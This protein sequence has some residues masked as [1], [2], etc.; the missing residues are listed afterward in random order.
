MIIRPD[1]WK[2]ELKVELNTFL[3]FLKIEGVN[4]EDFDYYLERF[5]FISAFIIRKLS[6]SNK[7]TDG[8]INGKYKVS[9]F[10]MNDN[11]SNADANCLY[12]ETKYDVGVI[13]PYCIFEDDFSDHHY[14]ELTLKDILNIIIHSSVLNVFSAA[15]DIN[16]ILITTEQRKGKLFYIKFGQMISI[17]QGCFI[18]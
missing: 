12:K 15:N 16:G 7:L 2:S 11:A 18:D 9:F 10:E 5:F 8:L 4:S 1:K 6:E 17:V 3:E 13:S 14:C